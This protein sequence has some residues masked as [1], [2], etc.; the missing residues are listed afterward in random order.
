MQCSGIMQPSPA[1]WRTSPI[2]ARSPSPGMRLR[3]PSSRS[4]GGAMCSTSVTGQNRR[5]IPVLLGILVLN[6]SALAQDLPA[7][8]PEA[9]GLSPDRLERI[10]TAVQHDIDDKRIAGAV[11][12]VVR[13]GKV[14]WFEAQGMSDREA[15]KAMPADAMFRICSMTKPITSVAVMMLYEEGKFLLDDPVSKYLPEFKNPKVLVKPAS[16]ATY[17]IPATKEITIRDLLRHT[18]GITYQWNDD[19]GPMYEKADVASG[20]LQFDGT[21]ADN[22]KHLAALPLLFNPGDRFEYSLGVDV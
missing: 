11:T 21:I 2:S 8:K 1:I 14:A 6:L 3:K 12:L 19:L 17:T 22:V 10:A 5:V 13:H 16:G 20:L 7:A 9:V 15:A 4:S 18:S